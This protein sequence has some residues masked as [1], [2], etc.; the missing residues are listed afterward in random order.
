[1]RVVDLRSDTVTKPSAAMREVMYRA[2][3]GDDVYSEDPTIH[4]LEE[5]AAEILGY[6]AGLYV[7]SGTQG[8]LVALLT[9]CGRGDEVILEEEA[10]IFFY[11]VA[12]MAAVGGLQAR[13]VKGPAGAKGALNPIEVEKAIRPVN[14]HFP[15]TGLVCLENTHNRGGGGASTPEQLG[16]IVDVAHRHGVPVH[17]DGARVF[18][19][20]VAQN[21]AAKRLVQGIDSVQMC[22]S[23]GLGAPV[24]SVLVGKRDWIERARRWRKMVG[25]GMRQAGIIAAAGVYA[26]EHNVDRLAEDHA[27]AKR[28]S[29]ALG[30]IT[31]FQPIKPDIPTNIVS[32]DVTGAGW[33]ANQFSG[34]MLERG[35]LANANSEKTVRFVTHL[36]VNGDDIEYAIKVISEVAAQ[37]PVVRTG[38]VY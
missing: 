3:V 12:G 5:K 22:L 33:T 35:I 8:N 18:N 29:E 37:G 13:T 31:G 11:E 1:M 27:K 16:A 17:L 23:K 14:V 9:H 21:V 38:T 26:L 30:N 6:E 2:E 19:A 7:T 15:T 4:R 28:L 20:A 10:H 34:A 24:G 32:V 25:G 36:D